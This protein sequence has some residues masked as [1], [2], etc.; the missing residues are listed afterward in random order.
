MKVYIG[1]YRNHHYRCDFFTK[2]GERKY[3]RT[4]FWLL[5]Q[6][7]YTPFERMLEK[8]EGFCQDILNITI[9]KLTAKQER[10]IKIRIDP[11]D[12]W[13]L[14]HTLSL[15]ILPMLQQLQATKH[16]S[17]WVDDED[18]PEE[19]RSTSAPEL[20]EQQKNRGATDELF[21]NRWEWVLGEMIHSF[22]C[23]VDDDWDSQFYSGTI[24]H[25]WVK[26]KETG[27]STMKSGPN[28]TFSVDNDARD[29]AYARRNNGL[30]LFAKYYNG[31][32]D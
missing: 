24:D 9:N 29:K 1:P 23:H 19:L 26:D 13:S 17:P 7:D 11:Y 31:L 5:E 8:V 12:T 22:E 3:G 2:W 30:R 27:L 18:V 25:D 15:I 10:K 14:D 28:H 20:T 6:E 32:W 21:H 16:G 4:E